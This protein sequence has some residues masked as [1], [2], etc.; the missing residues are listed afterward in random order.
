MRQSPP[1]SAQGN[2]IGVKSY[3]P[4]VPGPTLGVRSSDGV[5]HC[6]AAVAGSHIVGRWLIDDGSVNHPILLPLNPG[7]LPLSRDTLGK[8]DLS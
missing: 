1:G 2:N 8:C 3:I 5:A 4:E 7:P 6:P